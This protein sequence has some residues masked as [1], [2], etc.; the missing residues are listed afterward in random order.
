MKCKILRDQKWR[1]I[2]PGIPDFFRPTEVIYPAGS[3]CEAFHQTGNSIAVYTPDKSDF[4][5]LKISDVELLPEG[6]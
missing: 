5:Y 6:A 2:L 3:I 4:N 1:D